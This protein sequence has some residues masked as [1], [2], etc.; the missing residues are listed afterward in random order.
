MFPFPFL[1]SSHFPRS[2][3]VHVPGA[4][5]ARRPTTKKAKGIDEASNPLCVCDRVT[6]PSTP[7]TRWQSYFLSRCSSISP[8]LNYPT[9]ASQDDYQTTESRATE[10]SSRLHSFVSDF[11]D[12]PR[13]TPHA[14]RKPPQDLHP[15]CEG[16][17]L[18]G[19]LS[20][21][22]QPPHLFPGQSCAF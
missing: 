4:P 17:S 10:Q 7:R 3:G 13:S 12:S 5:G 22:T 19:S 15:L 20:S 16:P 18:S 11:P 8:L 1:H 9:A 21:R 6:A 14:R 2:T